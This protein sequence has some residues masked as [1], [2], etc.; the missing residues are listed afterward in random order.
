M[1]WILLH[2]DAQM[3]DPDISKDKVVGVW[4]NEVGRQV[5]VP[6]HYTAEDVER[7]YPSETLTD[8]QRQLAELTAK[9]NARLNE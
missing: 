5:R 9:I 1:A 4:E 8:L 7:E 3:T 6:Y 2:H